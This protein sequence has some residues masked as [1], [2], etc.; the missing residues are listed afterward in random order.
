MRDWL[1]ELLRE[2]GV[3]ELRHPVGRGM[4][5]GL[6]NDVFALR[7]VVAELDGRCNLFTSLNR[8]STEVRAT[9]AMGTR[10]LAD[11]DIIGFTRIVFDFDPVRPKDVP[12]T[13]AEV[14]AAVAVRNRLMST[15][16][17]LGWP[18]PATATSGNGVH[19]AYRVRLPADAATK[20]MLDA[21]FIGLDKSFS[22]D[23]VR[24]DTTVRN[25]ARV[26]R[27]YG[28]INV[29]GTHNHR[30]A[31]SGAPWWRFR[32]AG[33]GSLA[34]INRGPGEKY[35]AEAAAEK[36]SRRSPAR[37]GPGSLP[38]ITGDGDYR[39]LDV[40]GWFSSRDSY[41]R[42]LG[43]GKHAV[44]CPWSHEHSNEPLE[45]D[46]STVIW[47]TA[48]SNWPSFFC[49]PRALRWPQRPRHSCPVGRCGSVLQ[50]GMEYVLSD[51]LNLNG[52]P[53]DILGGAA[54]EEEARPGRNP[55]RRPP[56]E[57]D[58]LARV[59]ACRRPAAT[60]S[61]CARSRTSCARRRSCAPTWR[62]A[63]ALAARTRRR[64]SRHGVVGRRREHFG[65]TSSIWSS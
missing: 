46:S 65:L 45:F 10:A 40:V 5:S 12:S 11:A 7:K 54:A 31:S 50:Q 32:A 3:V 56:R 53:V 62:A 39:T 29:K 6:F 22:T 47:E 41:R 13:D 21:I 61:A 1:T 9:N 35:I 27:C 14:A 43:H 64:A 63:P 15:L 25:A 59:P 58:Q 60:A 18:A 57:R 55:T 19:L 8:P 23:A 52:D 33:E 51:Y 42:H 44:L 37:P 34:A 16:A 26:W 48:G 36:A 2:A 20:E 4:R 30:P 17:G 38:A 28:S 24:F 49:Q